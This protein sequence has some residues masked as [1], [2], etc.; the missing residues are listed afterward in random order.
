MPPTAIELSGGS[1]RAASCGRIDGGISR[2]ARR[3]IPL[4]VGLPEEREHA[5]R[6]IDVEDDPSDV[7]DGAR[8]GRDVARE[9]DQPVVTGR[10]VRLVPSGLKSRTMRVPSWEKLPPR[11]QTRP[12]W[13]TEQSL[14]SRR[15]AADGRPPRS[16]RPIWSI[17]RPTRGSSCRRGVSRAARCA[18]A[19]RPWP[20]PPARIR[21]RRTGSGRVRP[22]PPGTAAATPRTRRVPQRGMRRRGHTLLHRPS[23]YSPP[24]VFDRLR[25]ADCRAAWRSP[26]RAPMSNGRVALETGRTGQ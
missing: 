15:A 25:P 4:V 12:F 8:A 18:G 16:R 10:R 22:G 24:R 11:N 14:L 1:A 9:Q 2:T 6:G 21:S 26:K 3:R 7:V 20:T 23:W 5:G 17:A 19:P 13:L